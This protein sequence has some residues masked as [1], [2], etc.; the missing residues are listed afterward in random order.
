MTSLVH[1]PAPRCY[2]L[3]PCAGTG[4]RSGADRPKQY[5]PLAGR[6]LVAHTLDALCRVPRLAAT[7]VVLSPDDAAF[8]SAAPQAARDERVWTARCG[9][10]TRAATVAAGLEELLSRGASEG[11]W[12]LV[13]DAARCLLRPQWVTEL[14]Q[15]CEGDEVGG[16][17]ALP[18]ADTLKQEEGGRV[19]ATVDRGGKWAAQTPQMFRIGLLR[20]ALREAGDA[21]TDEASAIEALGLHPRL[22][23]GALE[24]FKLTWPADFGLAERLLSTMVAT[25]AAVSSPAGAEPSGGA[26]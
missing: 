26:R 14:I 17:L 18:V 23:P 16:L 15:A 8:E 6:A 7:L 21:V 12:V 13:H 5:V 20:R 2:A 4:S 24:N 19:A 22:V 11:D 25:S 10:A 9:G 1:G 3:V